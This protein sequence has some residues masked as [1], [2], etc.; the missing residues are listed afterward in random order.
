MLQEEVIYSISM[1]NDWRVR[2]SQP[3]LYFVNMCPH[4]NKLLNSIICLILIIEMKNK[5]L[6]IIK[7]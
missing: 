1:E 6:N 3:K 5:T 7:W 4:E 2:F